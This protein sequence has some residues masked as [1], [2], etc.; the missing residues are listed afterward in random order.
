MLCRMSSVTLKTHGVGRGDTARI[1]VVYFEVCKS[2]IYSVH[3]LAEDD[4]G[5]QR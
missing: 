5:L 4:D 1:P 2:F 3:L